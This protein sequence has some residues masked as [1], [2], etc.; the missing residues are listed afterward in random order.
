MKFWTTHLFG[1]FSVICFSLSSH[2]APYI[3][4]Q[5]SSASTST[6]TPAKIDEKL[7]EILYTLPTP[8]EPEKKEAVKWALESTS[9][10]LTAY[11]RHQEMH[12]HLDKLNHVTQYYADNVPLIE[13]KTKTLEM[14]SEQHLTVL[15][16]S[17]LSTDKKY[18]DISLLQS[19]LTRA[20]QSLTLPA[21]ENFHDHLV[22]YQEWPIA[23]NLR[24]LDNHLQK[25]LLM[26]L[27]SPRKPASEKFESIKECLKTHHF[28]YNE[29]TSLGDFKIALAEEVSSFK[30]E[31]VLQTFGMPLRPD[32][33]T[34]NRLLASV[35]N[36]SLSHFSTQTIL[37]REVKFF[38]LL[39]YETQ[40]K[41][42]D[43]IEKSC[44]FYSTHLNEQG[45]ILDRHLRLFQKARQ[46]HSMAA[47]PFNA[48]EDLVKKFSGETPLPTNQ[49]VSAL[50]DYCM[51]PLDM[52]LEPRTLRRAK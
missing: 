51:E 27:L 18:S 31:R 39:A 42:K 45:K 35:I 5:A 47:A 16:I 25:S 52:G 10:F 23:H 44:Q 3:D 46:A 11:Y 22:A 29:N 37:E 32:W 17:A 24:H 15:Y 49:L 2:T 12:D 36:G 14:L 38:T 34:Q 1:I 13:G 21:A 40:E 48:L 9:Q 7:H 19:I 41:A 43:Y 8:L 6:L 50:S 26:Q 33:K 4:D 20:Q 30:V 28:P